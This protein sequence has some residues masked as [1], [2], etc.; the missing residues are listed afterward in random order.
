MRQHNPKD[1]N[2]TGK[3][4]HSDAT[5]DPALHTP[6][7]RF[8]CKHSAPSKSVPSDLCRYVTSAVSNTQAPPHCPTLVVITA[9]VPSCHYAAWSSLLSFPS[10]VHIP[11]SCA[12]L[13]THTFTAHT[14]ANWCLQRAC[15]SAATMHMLLQ[16]IV[17]A[18][19]HDSLLLSFLRNTAS[20]PTHTPDMSTVCGVATAPSDQL[21]NLGQ[22]MQQKLGGVLSYNSPASTLLCLP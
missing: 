17:T 12:L 2:T 7:M 6:A 5:T 9:T 3:R 11:H 22:P 13:Q 14:P 4:I 21:H 10:T 20:A 15:T 1:R 8:A 16:S 18:E 19:Y